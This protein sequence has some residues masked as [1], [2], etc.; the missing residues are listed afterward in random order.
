[1]NNEEI[2]KK[3]AAEAWT[4]QYKKDPMSWMTSADY[5]EGFLAGYLAVR[6]K[7]RKEWNQLRLEMETDFRCGRS[8]A[9]RVLLLMDEL[10][11]K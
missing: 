7:G 2:E 8:H 1:M 4:M 5:Q 10:E 9:K 11:A 6:R 3:E